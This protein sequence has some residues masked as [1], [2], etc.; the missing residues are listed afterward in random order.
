MEKL[1]IR[2]D[3]LLLAIR[4]LE[5][6]KLYLGPRGWEGLTPQGAMRIDRSAEVGQQLKKL[7]FA[8]DKAFAL[9]VESRLVDGSMSSDGEITASEWEH[10]VGE[11]PRPA[12]HPERAA[13]AMLLLLGDIRPLLEDNFDR[14]AGVELDI[15]R[16]P[17]GAVALRPFL[18]PFA[19]GEITE[20]MLKEPAES[21]AAT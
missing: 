3:R 10:R 18:E 2:G 21:T 5:W 9:L 12:R 20:E 1:V 13:A 7:G 11:P 6:V 14:L 8:S 15:T 4:A 16:F 17:A 19:S